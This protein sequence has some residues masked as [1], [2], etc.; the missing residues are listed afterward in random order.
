MW[1]DISPAS[2]EPTSV[3]LALTRLWPVFHING[4]PP[5]LA[6]SSKKLWLVL[7]SAMIV[8]PGWRVSTSAAR[9]CRIWSP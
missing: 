7:T 1:P 8:A 3:I 6:T 5:S 2:G 4:T 9:I